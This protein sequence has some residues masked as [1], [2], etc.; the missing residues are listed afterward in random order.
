MFFDKLTGSLASEVMGV[1]T[2]PYYTYYMQ[3]TFGF[4][5]LKGNGGISPTNGLDSLQWVGWRENW[6]DTRHQTHFFE[7][8]SDDFAEKILWLVFTVLFGKTHDPMAD[9]CSIQTWN[10]KQWEDR[11]MFIGL[12]FEKNKGHKKNNVGKKLWGTNC[13]RFMCISHSI[14]LL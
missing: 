2:L 14:L 11:G 5:W 13:G 9:T 6:E 3:E 10:H 4:H 12:V 8:S 1:P 7:V